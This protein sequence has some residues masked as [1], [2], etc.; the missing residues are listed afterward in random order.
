MN[1]NSVN[2]GDEMAESLFEALREVNRKHFHEIWER[3]K[4]GELQDLTQ[5]EQAL[6][7]IMLDHSDEYFNQFEFADA[8]SDHEYDPDNEVNPFLHVTLHTVAENQIQN[9][10]PIEA[11]QFYNAML[12]NKCSRHE[13]IHLLMTILIKFLFPVLKG[14]GIFPLKEYREFLKMCKFRK[15]DKIAR[16]L[17]DEPDHQGG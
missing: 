1:G 4:N 6:G 17:Q 2:L 8:M 15:P 16:L 13:T 12:R 5:E 10:D 9:R 11:F 7:K 14:E 3:A